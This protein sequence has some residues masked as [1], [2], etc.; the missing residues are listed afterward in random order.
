MA[1]T[2]HR[3]SFITAYFTF[4]DVHGPIIE[5]RDFVEKFASKTCS[6]FLLQ[7]ITATA[8]LYVSSDVISECGFNSK[9]EAQATFAARATLLYDFQFETELLVLLQGSIL[10]TRILLDQPTDKDFNYW[11]YNAF[12]LAAKLEIYCL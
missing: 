10:M 9:A 2:W 6:L 4:V 8:S 3:I 11:F 12:R 7:V 1:I 5:K